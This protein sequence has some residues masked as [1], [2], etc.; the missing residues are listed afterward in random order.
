MKQE[1]TKAI[2]RIAAESPFEGEREAAK[3]ALKRL[4]VLWKGMKTKAEMEG[5]GGWDYIE[6]VF[7]GA[8]GNVGRQ[9]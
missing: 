5:K 3:A 4:G 8:K 6:D 1:K 7:G 2:E 9:Q